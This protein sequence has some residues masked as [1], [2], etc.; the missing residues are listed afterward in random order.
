MRVLSAYNPVS[1]AV[2]VARENLFATV[3]YAYPPEVYLLG[4]LAWAVVLI[5]IALVVATRQLRTK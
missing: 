1:L 2:N 3:G 5:G 4:L